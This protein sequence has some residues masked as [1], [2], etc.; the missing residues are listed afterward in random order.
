MENWRNLIPWG[1]VAPFLIIILIEYGLSFG[2]DFY[3]QKLNQQISELE[4]NLKQKEES[5]KGDLGTNEAFKAFSQSI[6]IVEILKNRQSLSF[7]INK[8]NQLM[9]KFLII[10][11]FKYDAEK[12]EIEVNATV[13]NWQDYLRFHK[14]VTGLQVL[15]LKNFTSPK[16][17]ENN[18]INFSMVFLLKPNF[19]KQ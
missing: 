8:F 4:A 14:Y 3:N 9:P 7:I 13:S 19:F 15:E 10:K 17:D 16:V 5:T 1:L 18:L 12:R 11:E 2:I 6:N